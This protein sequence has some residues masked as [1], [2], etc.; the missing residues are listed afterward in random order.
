MENGGFQLRV[1][2]VWLI[3][4]ER[5]PVSLSINE[6]FPTAA[7]RSLRTK[8]GNGNI[9]DGRF[10]DWAINRTNAGVDMSFPSDAKNI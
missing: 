6:D 1:F 2:V 8:T 4:T 7:A 9:R 5:D 3:S 10:T